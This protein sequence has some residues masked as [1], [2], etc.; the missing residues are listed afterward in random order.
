[1]TETPANTTAEDKK[2]N[3]LGLIL[4]LL[5]ATIV[6]VGLGVWQVQRLGW[7]E[8]LIARVDSRIH[9]TAQPAPAQAQWPEITR[10][11]D[12]YRHVKVT[13]IYLNQDE[14]LVYAS[15]DLGPG[16]WVVTPLKQA[17][18]SYVLINRGFVPLDKKDPATRPGSQIDKAVTVTGLLRMSEPG[19]GFLRAN[20]PDQDRW[21][22][23]DV[24]AMARKDGLAPVAPY[25][26]DADKSATSDTLPV[27]GL[28]Q[29]HFPNNHLQYA[30]T[31]FA[32]AIMSLGFVVYILRYR[33]RAR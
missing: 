4:F 31:W 10:D 5:F 29:V 15:T 14:R 24:V 3:K 19:G 11:K 28:T 23:R 17:D 6:F 20:K 9:A 2:P 8:A 13:G 16:Y 27:G 32:M 21:Y 26:I 12:E 22:S 25:F 33:E 1:M 30:L 18:G 7:K